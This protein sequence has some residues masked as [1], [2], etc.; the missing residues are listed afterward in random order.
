MTEQTKSIIA[1]F[2][3]TLDLKYLPSILIGIQEE[4]NASEIISFRSC[5]RMLRN[6]AAHEPFTI[7]SQIMDEKN[8]GASKIVFR[9]K[10]DTLKT[11]V[12]VDMAQ[13]TA[14]MFE[15]YIVT[16][17]REYL[18]F[19]KALMHLKY[20]SRKSNSVKR[21]F[22][23]N[24]EDYKNG[25]LSMFLSL[26]EYLWQELGMVKTISAIDPYAIQ[27]YQNNIRVFWR[28]AVP[29]MMDIV[30]LFF[31][32]AIDYTNKGNISGYLKLFKER[33]GV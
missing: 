3:K 28:M 29:N 26:Q 19:W 14:W 24:P 12:V 7:T 9:P 21:A 13:F 16:S 27:L 6:L 11:R 23:F 30:M 5:L 22:N 18:T 20:Q 1:D 32:G 15:L 2:G 33:E 8:K 17:S 10:E 25:L 31:D 4:D